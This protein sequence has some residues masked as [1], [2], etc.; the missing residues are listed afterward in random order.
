MMHKRFFTIAC[1]LGA[2]AVA[3]GAFGAHSLKT[4]L[5]APQLVTFETGVRYQFYHVFALLITAIAFVHYSNRL[6]VFAGWSF[7]IGIIL[8]SGS[9]YALTY[10]Q[11]ADLTGFK[12]LGPITPLGGFAFIL[13]WVMLALAAIKQK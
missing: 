11:A 3:L 4:L 9:L 10:V 2:L 8:F 5:T 6:M 7:I 13:G 1:I 12:W